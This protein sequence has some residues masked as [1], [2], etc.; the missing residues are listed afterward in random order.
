MVYLNDPVPVPTW[1][2]ESS[3]WRSRWRRHA[4]GD[5]GWV[6]I[7]LIKSAHNYGAQRSCRYICTTECVVEGI[8]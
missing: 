8:R 1:P 3:R 2:S 5:P 7:R 4:C 6:E